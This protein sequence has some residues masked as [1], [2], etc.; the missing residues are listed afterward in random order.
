MEDAKREFAASIVERVGGALDKGCRPIVAGGEDHFVKCFTAPTL[1]D[2][3]VAI[4]ALN[5]GINGEIAV[6][7]VV[8]HLVVHQRM[9]FQKLVIW[10]RQA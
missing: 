4:E 9:G 6:A 10:L 7:K 5:I 3:L 2:D 8:E 1:E